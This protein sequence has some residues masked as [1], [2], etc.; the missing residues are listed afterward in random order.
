[1]ELRVRH[2]DEYEEAYRYLLRVLSVH[3]KLVPFLAEKANAFNI[4][5][6]NF[7]KRHLKDL[8]SAC[9]KS[10]V[11]VAHQTLLE[12]AP[13]YITLLLIGNE[14]DFKNLAKELKKY[15]SSRGWPLRSLKLVR[16]TK[17]EISE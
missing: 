10:C 4:L 6:E 5:V 17:K 7:P 8:V 12:W 2:F 13:D 16:F 11:K 3:E 1:M 14:Y 9:E 15:P